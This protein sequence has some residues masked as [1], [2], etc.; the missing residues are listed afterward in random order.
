MWGSCSKG[1]EIEALKEFEVVRTQ[2]F[3]QQ[4]LINTEL[5]NDRGNDF[6]ET[7]GGP[8]VYYVLTFV[9]SKSSVSTNS[10]F[11]ATRERRL[12]V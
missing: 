3:A 6:T 1:T 9:S 7:Q 4:R 5:G 8:A 11:L 12:D 2:D 10:Y